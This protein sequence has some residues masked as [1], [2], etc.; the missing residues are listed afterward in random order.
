MG[1]RV[2]RTGRELLL[3]LGGAQRGIV[4]DDRR[5]D[6]G[7]VGGRA[8]GAAVHSGHLGGRQRG[9]D[10][11]HAGGRA[12]RGERLGDVDDAPAAERDEEGGRRE[13]V[14][15]RAG[16]LVHAAGTDVQHALGLLDDAWGERPG[17]LG[18]QQRVRLVEEG[19]RVGEGAAAEADQTLAILPREPASHCADSRSQRVRQVPGLPSDG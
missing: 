19:G 17:A 6:A 13:L 14:E 4:E 16:E 3:G 7:D 18:C 2:R 12:G 10:G 5:P 15:Q 11:R 8:R 1:E 9:R